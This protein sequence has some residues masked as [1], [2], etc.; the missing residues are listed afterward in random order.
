MSA[1]N[2]SCF[3]NYT[4]HRSKKN[5]QL[6][7]KKKSKKKEKINQ[8]GKTSRGFV[9]KPKKTGKLTTKRIRWV[10]TPNRS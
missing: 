8:A 5:K 1:K 4:K 9:R 3:T 10:W 2:G 7:E 6:K